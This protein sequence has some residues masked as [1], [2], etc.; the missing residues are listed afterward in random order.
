M[1]D[2]AKKIIY[3][4]ETQLEELF[5]NGSITVDGKTITYN[6][7]DIYVTPQSEPVTGVRVDGTSIVNNGVAD[8]PV[9]TGA[10]QVGLVP[11]PNNSNGLY[12]FNG[13]LTIYPASSAH[14]KSGT[15]SFLPIT[16]NHQQESTFYGLAK[17]AG[18]ATQST[19][20]NAVGTYTENAKSAISTMLNGAVQVTGQNP[21][22][23]AN[24][25]IRYVCGEVQ[26]ITVTPPAS[27]IFDVTFTSGST[28]AVLTMNGVVFPDWFDP[29]ALDADTVYEINVMDGRAVV[30]TWAVS[31]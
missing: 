7:N 11:M 31:N 9:I 10:K 28:A 8:I 29:D 23:T 12:I 14:V 4:S 6:E 15:A 27:G 26:T 1:P 2:Y 5:D 25:G 13:D 24:D 19:S 22:I 16:P 3:L 20:A 18:D 17:A 30:A 21:V